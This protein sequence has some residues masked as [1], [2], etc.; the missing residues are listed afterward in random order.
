MVR[1]EHGRAVANA[2]A[3]R[4]VVAPHRSGGQAQFIEGA[5]AEPSTEG[6]AGLL[7]W[8]RSHL[9]HPLTVEQLARRAV[10]SPRTFARHFRAATGTTPH[11]WLLDQRL[12][13]AEHLLEVT[14]LPVD[15]V[16]RRSGFGSPDNLRH[17]FALRRRTTP[18]S[19]RRTFGG[20]S[21]KNGR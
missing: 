13:S 1:S 5:V 19:Y 14:D 16:A 4:M 18:Q 15:E 11:Q 12:E 20:D 7:D 17:H 21:P 9:A 6:I 2:L 3:R 10:L 8:M